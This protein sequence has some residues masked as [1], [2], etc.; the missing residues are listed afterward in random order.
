MAK[1]ISNYFMNLPKK[2]AQRAVSVAALFRL[3]TKLGVSHSNNWP[4]TCENNIESSRLAL[5]KGNQQMENRSNLRKS[6]AS[7]LLLL[8][9][10]A[11]SHYAR[12]ADSEL[13][14][15]GNLLLNM[16]SA[17]IKVLDGQATNA[18]F[19]D[20]SFCLGYVAGFESGHN[21]TVFENRRRNKNSNVDFVFCTTKRTVSAGQKARVV[22]KFLQEHPQSLDLP[23]DV[24]TQVALERAFP[25]K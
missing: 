23:M 20:S 21:L 5:R 14:T 17:A 7:S 10:A 11:S 2:K 25:C 8:V 4:K 22:L 1:S 18:D 13:K 24:L 12:A 9:V 16:C 15:D 19:S 6:V 3:Q